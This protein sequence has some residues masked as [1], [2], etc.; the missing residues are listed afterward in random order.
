MLKHS[1]QKD[2]RAAP[3]RFQFT[4][5]HQLCI[6]FATV[7]NRMSSFSSV[8]KDGSVAP[9]RVQALGLANTAWAFATVDHRMSSFS[10]RWQGWQSGNWTTSVH[11][12]SPLCRDL[13][14]QWVNRMSSFS[15]VDKNGS[16][17]PGRV[18]CSGSRQHAWALAQWVNRLSSLSKR[19]QDGSV[20]HGRVQCAGSCQRCM[21]FY[22]TAESMIADN[23]VCLVAVTQVD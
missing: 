19:W 15:S 5:P 23:E 10:K 17:A 1:Y 18:Q 20:V 2:G 7:V 3:R 21:G 22:N 9:G 11:M 6:G 8:G 16:G 13:R 12:V 4:G 14:R